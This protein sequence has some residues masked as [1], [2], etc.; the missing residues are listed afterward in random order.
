MKSLIARTTRE[1][2]LEKEKG[3]WVGDDEICT[4]VLVE[5]L[6]SGAAECRSSDQ[7]GEP[8]NERTNERMS[9]RAGGRAVARSLCR[10]KQRARVCCN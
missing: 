10:V 9:G 5:S 1:M 2:S 8:A 3:G 6:V 7:T 4:R